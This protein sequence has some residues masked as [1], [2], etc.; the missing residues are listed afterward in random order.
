MKN[1]LLEAFDAAPF[2]EIKNEHFKPA[3][4]TAIAAARAEID[5]ITTQEAAPSFQNTIELW[6]SPANNWIASAA[7]SLTSTLPRPMKPCNR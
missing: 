2:S 5:A 6:S 7:Y 1:P 3:I 4:T